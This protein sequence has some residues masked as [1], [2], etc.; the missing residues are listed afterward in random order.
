MSEAIF[1]LRLPGAGGGFDIASFRPLQ[2][3]SRH[4]SRK[5]TV[6]DTLKKTGNIHSLQKS[7]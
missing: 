4:S 1:F 7:L 6:S 2:F 3:L 5:V